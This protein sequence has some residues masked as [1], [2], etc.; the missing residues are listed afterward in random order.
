MLVWWLKVSVLVN[1]PGL[2]CKL[3]YWPVI[4]VDGS[5]GL[6]LA[7]CAPTDSTEKATSLGCF[8]GGL[9]TWMTAV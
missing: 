7:G 6:S 9:T 3:E 1:W 8:G 5:L 4:T 2:G